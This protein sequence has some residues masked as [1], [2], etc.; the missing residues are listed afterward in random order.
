MQHCN[1]DRDDRAQSYVLGFVIFFAFLLLAVTAWQVGVVPA[2]NEEVEYGHNQQV[3]E[4]LQELRSRMV[5]ASAGGRGGTVD[6]PLGT[7]YPDRTLYRNPQPP[8]GQLRT[9][10][11]GGAVTVNVSNATPVD[12]ETADFWGTELSYDTVLVTY[13][14]GYHEYEDAP[15]TVL[16]NTLLYDR[17][18]STTIARSPQSLVDGKR[19]SLLVASGNV[20]ETRSGVTDDLSLQVTPTSTSTNTVRVENDT[21][22]VTLTVTSYRPAEFWNETLAAD[23]QLDEDGGYVTDVVNRTQ[24]PVPTAGGE[25]LHRVGITFVANETYAVQTTRVHLGTASEPDPASP[26]PAYVTVVDGD[27]SVANA[28]SSR[29]FT[30]EIR[31]AYNNPVPGATV[32]LTLDG[33]PGNLTVDGTSRRTF[34]GLRVG[35]DGRVTARYDAPDSVTT[36][37]DVTVNVSL[38]GDPRSGFDASAP[39]NATVVTTVTPGDGGGGGGGGGA[40]GS[41]GG[42][43][44]VEWDRNST[45]TVDRTSSPSRTF[46]A[47]IVEGL[48]NQPVE[49]SVNNT[50]V[51]NIASADAQTNG[52]GAADATF[53]LQNDGTFLAYVTSGGSG[54]RLVV[55]V[56]SGALSPLVWQTA[57]DWDAAT[58]ESNVV[59]ANHGDHEAGA[60]QLGYPTSGSGLVAYYPL[61]ENGGSTADDASGGNDGTVDGATQGVPGILNTSAYRFDGLD[62]SVQAPTDLS[63]TL[64]TSG[65]VSAWI[66]TTQSGSDTMW[67]APGITGVESNGDANDVFYGW[68]DASGNIGVMAGNEAGAQSATEINDGA[69]HHVVLTRNADSGET[70]VYVDGVLED[71]ATSDAGAKTTPFSGIGVIEDTGG[72]PEYL[73]GRLDEVRLY[74]RALSDAEAR[75]LY[76][77]SRNGTITTAE[78]T[79]SVTVDPRTIRLENVTAD[80]PSGTSLTVYVESDPED[81]GTWNRSDPVSIV[82]GQESYAVGDGNFGTSSDRF[83]VVVELNSTAPSQS[84]CLAGLTV[85]PDGANGVA[86]TGDCPTYDASGTPPTA[87]FTAS[88]SSPTTR[89]S[90]SVD[91]TGSSDPDG[92]ISSYQWDFGDGTTASGPTATHTYST[93]GTYTVTLTAT[94]DDGLTDSATRTVTVRPAALL[95]GV[96]PNPDALA[97]TDGEFVAVEVDGPLNTSDW[98]VRDDESGTGATLA[99]FPATSDGTLWFVRNASAFQAQWSVPADVTLVEFQPGD[100]IGVLANDGE[101]LELVNTSSGV[102]V[103]EFAYG[104]ATTSDGWSYTYANAT[105]V[106]TRNGDGA[107]WYVDTDDPSDWSDVVETDFFDPA[108]N[109]S[110]DY[111]PPTPDTSDSV[112]FD[113]TGST[114]AGSGSYQWDFGDGTTATG[115]T[116]THSYD[117]SGTY[118]VTL[119]ITDENGDTNTTTR[120]VTVTQYTPP[121]FKVTDL[122]ATETATPGETITVNTTVTNTGETADTQYVDYVFNA[123]DTLTVAVVDDGGVYGSDIAST[124]RSRLPDD[125]SVVVVDTQTAVNQMGSYDAVVVQR[126]G[127]DT[128]LASSFVSAVDSNDVGAVY[129]DQWT[130]NPSASDYSDGIRR[131]SQVRGD[132]SSVQ[133]EFQGTPPIV[134]DITQDHPIFDGVGDVGDTITIHDSAT[135]SNADRVW[136]TGYSGDTLAQVREEGSGSYDGP[137]ILADDDANE[138]LLGMGRSQYIP[139]EQYTSEANNVL[140]SAVEHVT[141]T[142]GNPS[143]ATEI[144][145][146]PGESRTLTYQVTVPS[147]EGQYEQTVSTENDSAT[148]TVTISTASQFGSFSGTVTDTTAGTPLANTDVTFTFDGSTYTTTTDANGDY[149]ITTVPA[150]SY[151]ANATA[152]AYE[153]SNSFPLAVQDGQTTENV[154]VSLSRAQPGFDALS[155]SANENWFFGLYADEVTFDYDFVADTNVDSVEL[156]VRNS[157]GT[158]VGSTTVTDLDGPITVSLNSNQYDPMTVEVTATGPGGQ[159]CW[160]GTVDHGDTIAL[161]EFTSC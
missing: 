135:D 129:L 107:G 99:T 47:R 81:D 117:T 134:F 96:Q 70:R 161:G 113:A 25:T 153:T 133:Q 85:E 30:V 58:V 152:T 59:H 101:P 75:A 35:D 102:V 79:T 77:T 11:G 109:A 97:D 62:D 14:P 4:Q 61:D 88:P 149:E 128:T 91:G 89:E 32:N 136:T 148:D 64:G 140:A 98:V 39:L 80:V 13:R 72:S 100:E 17:Y 50:N 23:G 87:S 69:W 6:I 92:S 24:T 104:T 53:D 160:E 43:F 18:D 48:A 103:D 16:D 20:S 56:V 57:A 145:L 9:V 3:H 141:V 118:T 73:D 5:S 139:N 108:P 71:T 33:S 93:P 63:D 154:D 15:T 132:P 150:G 130:N 115:D 36:A 28:G 55:E 90:L 121:F 7:T 112:T 67:Q 116:P 74:D 147:T 125:Y 34:T 19:L 146:A 110:F 54:D 8:V 22:P 126:L 111:S 29:E 123:S 106:A 124:L 76:E 119:T 143:N 94:D 40:G 12:G 105:G 27:D 138:V 1:H 83:R 155:A 2:Q 68:I 78:K 51:A 137:T 127:T 42:A 159:T 131:L 45:V 10:S 31:D 49:F 142:A 44:T 37:T 156:V 120:T 21:G 95:T 60:V 65:T 26:D 144:T 122:S 52:S 82:G 114:V 157:G 84:P 158:V 46:T 66:K 151:T 41:T 86:V 38:S